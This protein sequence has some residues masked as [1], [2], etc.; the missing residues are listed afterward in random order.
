M[1]QRLFTPVGSEIKTCC[2]A[3][4]ALTKTSELAM[5]KRNKEALAF[6][7]VREIKST[8]LDADEYNQAVHF[9]DV[10]QD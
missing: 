4:I 7:M 2:C 9:F 5:E 1:L 10:K 6:D 8:M 3:A